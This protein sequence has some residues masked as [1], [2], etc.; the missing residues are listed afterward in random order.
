MLPNS[1][2]SK[3][4]AAATSAARAAGTSSGREG[5]TGQVRILEDLKPFP[6]VNDCKCSK[7]R[8]RRSGS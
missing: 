4:L 3:E 2:P 1:S 5:S 7:E 6:L 8:K